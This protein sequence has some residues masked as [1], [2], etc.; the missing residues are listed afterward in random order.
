V[1]NSERLATIMIAFRGRLLLTE[2]KY[3][4]DCNFGSG[5]VV[6]IKK[7]ILYYVEYYVRV[8]ARRV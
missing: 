4:G 1:I 6:L 7:N 8:R 5:V 3:A 2:N